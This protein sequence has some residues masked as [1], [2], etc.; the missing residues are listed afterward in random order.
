[1]RSTLRYQIHSKIW[2]E[3]LH[4]E[5][6]HRIKWSVHSLKNN[7][8]LINI[9]GIGYCPSL[10]LRTK[11]QIICWN[12]ELYHSN[13]LL[14]TLCNYDSKIFW[15]ED[16]KSNR[17]AHWDIIF[18]NLASSQNLTYNKD[19]EIIYQNFGLV[20]NPEVANIFWPKYRTY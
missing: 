12:F 18:Q 10:S 19:I 16:T 4:T 11:L 7:L 2:S 20:K 5:S 17:T 15:N 3:V 14:S 9:I 6:D 1:M 8:R 13:S